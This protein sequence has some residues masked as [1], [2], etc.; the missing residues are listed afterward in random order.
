MLSEMFNHT[1]VWLN[2]SAV[3]EQFSCS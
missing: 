3:V 1:V 2:S